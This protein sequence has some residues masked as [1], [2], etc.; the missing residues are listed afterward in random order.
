MNCECTVQDNS[1]KTEDKN[2][3]IAGKYC[4]ANSNANRK[5]LAYANE[6]EAPDLVSGCFLDVTHERLNNRLIVV[7][8]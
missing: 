2:Q 3:D 4:D 5:R 1:H 6:R 7:I 8:S